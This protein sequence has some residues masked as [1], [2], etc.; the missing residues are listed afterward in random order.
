MR[1]IVILTSC[2]L[3][4]YNPLSAFADDKPVSKDISIASKKEFED[5]KEKKKDDTQLQGMI[6]EPKI[7]LDIREKMI[8]EKELELAKKEKKLT[9]EYAALEISRKQLVQ[10]ALNV[11]VALNQREKEINQKAV[12]KAANN[13]TKPKK[14][15]EA[16][17]KFS[18]LLNS[19]SKTNPISE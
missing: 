13:K 7:E 11:K 2:L 10:E 17:K 4:L 18:D 19:V 3:G 16:T 1:K 12:Q 14:Y 6:T 5:Q 8:A 9:D 15:P